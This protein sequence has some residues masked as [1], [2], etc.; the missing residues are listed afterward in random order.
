MAAYMLSLVAASALA[1]ASPGARSWQLDVK[2]HDPQRIS[3]R[4][5]G[6][7]HPTTFWYMLYKV[8]N[9]TGQD[10][11]FFPSF[12]LLTGTLK[13]VEGGADVHPLVY[14]AI[15]AR[16]NDE[17]PF[18]A[19]PGK[20]AGL[21]LQG[22][23]NA[24]AS[25]AVF[26]EFDPDADEF[27]VFAAGFSGEIQRLANP[28]FDAGKGESEDNP[29]FFILRRTLAIRYELPGDATTRSRATPIRRTRDW[30]MR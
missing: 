3:L 19:P 30:V 28:A 11:Q 10:R 24:R 7:S 6:D 1:D 23:A 25:A 22:N 12:R 13:V 17:F 26:R 21:L 5:P 9:N 18:L 14:D 8:T 2:F 4:L 20:V 16:H 27:T 29:R 15:A